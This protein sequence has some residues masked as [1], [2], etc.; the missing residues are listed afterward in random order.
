MQKSEKLQEPFFIKIKK[1]NF[2]HI[3]PR[4]QERDLFRNS[5]TIT[6]LS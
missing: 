6:F 1:S 4:N 5:D 2:G 3:R